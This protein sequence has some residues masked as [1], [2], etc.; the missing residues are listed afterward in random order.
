[1]RTIEDLTDDEVLRE[2]HLH[3]KN[4]IVDG[5][6]LTMAALQ[7]KLNR[8]NAVDPVVRMEG[9][10][11]AIKHFASLLYGTK[12]PWRHVANCECGVSIRRPL[13]EGTLV[14]I[15]PNGHDPRCQPDVEEMVSED[16]G[17]GD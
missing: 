8:E 16:M 2:W 6:K 4:R 12:S 9:Q 17:D 15:H 10:D 1:M 14:P 7:E 5:L 13:E 11:A 3:F